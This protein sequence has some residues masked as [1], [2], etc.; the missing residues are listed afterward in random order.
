MSFLKGIKSAYIKAITD[1]LNVRLLECIMKIEKEIC[2][3][4][5]IIIM[6]MMMMITT[7]QT[8]LA[9]MSKTKMMKK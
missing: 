9:N 5:V 1:E 4:K 8:R 6:M 2:L 7:S 3:K